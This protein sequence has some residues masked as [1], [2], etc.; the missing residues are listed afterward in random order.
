[1]SNLPFQVPPLI[2][3]PMREENLSWLGRLVA[4][5]ISAICL[6][7][8]IFALILVPS[9]SGVGTH[10]PLGMGQCAWLS[11]FNLPCPSCGM[12][13]SFSWFV[14]GNWMASFYV[15]PFGFALALAVGI[16]FWAALYIGLSGKPVGRLLCLVPAKYTWAAVLVLAVGAWGWK[17]FIHLQGIDGWK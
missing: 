9:P 13:T 10:T 5:A 7:T 12:T 4:L 3:T 14:R 17:I 15:Q 6:A 16:V 11:R 8:L 2:S 1:M